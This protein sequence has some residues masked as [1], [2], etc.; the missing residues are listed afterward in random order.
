M[1]PFNRILLDSD[2][3][4]IFMFCWKDKNTRTVVSYDLRNGQM[5]EVCMTVS[6]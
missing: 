2:H 4:V 6:F 5:E 1:D 3:D